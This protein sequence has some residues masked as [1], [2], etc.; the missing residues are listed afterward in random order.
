M[1]NTLYPVFV[2]QL[3]PYRTAADEAIP[4]ALLIGTVLLT[5]A[6]N[7]INL[8]VNAVLYGTKVSIPVQTREIFLAVRR[9]LLCF[10]VYDEG[11]FVILS[12]LADLSSSTGRTPDW[13]NRLLRLS[14][15]IKFDKRKAISAYASFMP[16]RIFQ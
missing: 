1:P 8:P 9:L 7:E 14:T 5:F 10:I 12:S 13:I 2:V 3:F 11:H 4:E 6:F 16:R 15:A